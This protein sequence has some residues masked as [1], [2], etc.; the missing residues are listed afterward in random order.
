VV[1]PGRHNAAAEAIAFRLMNGVGL[2]FLAD[3]V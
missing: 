2:R 1:H 3:G